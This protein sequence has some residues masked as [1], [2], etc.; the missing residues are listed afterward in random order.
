MWLLQALRPLPEQICHTGLSFFQMLSTTTNV[1]RTTCWS[2][3]IATTSVHPQTLGEAPTSIAKIKTEN[4]HSWKRNGWTK[5]W[6]L[7]WKPEGWVSR[8]WTHEN[9]RESLAD[10][11][12][13]FVPRRL[14]TDNL[15]R[16]SHTDR[17]HSHWPNCFWSFGLQCLRDHTDPYYCTLLLCDLWPAPDLT[18]SRVAHPK[19]TKSRPETSLCRSRYDS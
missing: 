19:H 7:I 6:E 18:G 5:V 9:G 10:S 16:V 12:E 1:P 15:R 17:I 3:K 4:W 13:F 11:L 14:P 8:R 2:T